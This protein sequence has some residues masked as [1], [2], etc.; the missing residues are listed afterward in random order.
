[1]VKE[2]LNI[3]KNEKTSRIV[4]VSLFVFLF[5]SLASSAIVHLYSFQVINSIY[6]KERQVLRGYDRYSLTLNTSRFFLS[7]YIVT[8]SEDDIDQAYNWIE[9]SFPYA[10]IIERELKSGELITLADSILEKLEEVED[11]M[12][13][14]PSKLNEV[15]DLIDLAT[16]TSAKY[17]SKAQLDV[18]QDLKRRHALFS[19]GIY[20]F[21]GLGLVCLGLFIYVFRILKSSEKRLAS[22]NST[23]QELIE[24]QSELANAKLDAINAN[25]VER[26]GQIIGELS[27]ELMNPLSIIDG[28]AGLATSRVEAGVNNE[29]DMENFKRYISMIKTNSNRLVAIVTSLKTISYMN[30]GKHEERF[31]TNKLLEESAKIHKV[32]LKGND[33]TLTIEE[34]DQHYIAISKED[35]SQIFVQLF[36]NSVDAINKHPS[37]KNWIR[38]GLYSEGPYSYIRISDSGKLDESIDPVKL[39]NLFYSSKEN[40]VGLGL[41]IVSSLMNK[42]GGMFYFEGT[43]PTTFVLKFRKPN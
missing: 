17:E 19:R 41:S 3:T 24:A 13:D 36:S 39:T 1:M 30:T 22:L 33:I 12:K 40:N 42:R 27:H 14:N 8:F 10:K 15:F 38:I 25:Y 11:E 23:Q 37:D 31:L 32:K 4:V 6:T 26:V 16:K 29:K 7:K 9:A 28:A 18:G 21:V 20:L 5:I 34:N 35:F 2:K 43:N